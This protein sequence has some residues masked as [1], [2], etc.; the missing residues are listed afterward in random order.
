MAN[1]L[2]A[3]GAYGREAT[4]ADWEAGKDFRVVGGSYFSNREIEFIRDEYDE[5]QFVDM[6]CDKLFAVKL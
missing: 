1:T 4:L 2:F 5:I 6:K 3:I